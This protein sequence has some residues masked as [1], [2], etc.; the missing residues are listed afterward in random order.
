M[1]L[2]ALFAQ[3]STQP[4][5]AEKDE[6][7]SNS[8]EAFAIIPNLEPEEISDTDPSKSKI[9]FKSSVKNCSVYLNG[10]LQGRTSLTLTNLVD[11]FYLLRLEKSG[12]LPQENFIYAEHGK[13][14][15]FYIEMQPTEETKKKME[16][17]ANKEVAKENAA[18]PSSS[19]ETVKAEESPDPTSAGQTSSGDAK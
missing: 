11:G 18:A 1:S 10:N 4:S 14:K 2:P 19:T 17:R 13:N 15:T 16:A 8:A 6:A 9:I 5:Q 12:Y 7:G 3:E